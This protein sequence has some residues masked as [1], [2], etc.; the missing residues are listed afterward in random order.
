MIRTSHSHAKS[1][2]NTNTSEIASALLT[3]YWMELETVQNYLCNSVNLVGVRAERIKQSLAAD[4]TEE[5]SHAQ[6]I[7]KR[8]HVIGAE[9]PGSLKF[10]PSQKVLQPPSDPADTEQVIRGVIQAEQ[11]AIE[12]YMRIIT[13][14]EDK[15]Y[16]TQDMCIKLLADEERHHREFTDY[17]AEYEK[18]HG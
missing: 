13:L 3:A 1:N 11:E 12:Q 18:S 6:Q 8:M 17:L 2:T 14:C 10:K 7:A 15:D 16:A 5:L 9:V 4:V